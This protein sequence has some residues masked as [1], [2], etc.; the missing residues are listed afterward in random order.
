MYEKTKTG[1]EDENNK[2]KY[3][4]QFMTEDNYYV[5]INLDSL[6]NKI[7]FNAY[8][9]EIGN[10][11]YSKEYSYEELSNYRI[12]KNEKNLVKIYEL[13]SKSIY[14]Y[15][16]RTKMNDNNNLVLIINLIFDDGKSSNKQKTNFELNKIEPSKEEIINTLM[17]KVNFLICE[18]KNYLQGYKVKK[19]IDENKEEKIKS[20]INLLEKNIDLL[21]KK[22]KVYI[23]S[24]LLSCSNIINTL[25]DWKF[26]KERLK[27]ID[28]KYNSILF[29]LVYR[30][31]RDGD[32]AE[33]FHK[34]C[35]TIGP[36]I[37]MVLTKD[38]HRFGGFTKNN[39]EHLKVDIKEKQPE[40]GSGKSD[41]H[42]FCFSIDLHKIYN[43]NDL[44]NGVIFCCNK[45]GPTFCRNIF[46]INDQMLTKGGYCLK[47][48][49]SCF[50]GQEINYEISGGKKVFGIKEVEVLEIIFI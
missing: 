34:K 19:L 20:R 42:A 32:S 40:V 15:E 7:I 41:V 50:E 3:L 8:I 38:N 22:S 1:N 46:A 48:N 47:K 33:N 14:Y 27:K 24:N 31:S 18:K 13:I 5:T 36:N 44:D 6:K 45:Y 43:N 26:L 17:D 4:T 9:Q 29:K 28:P 23:D 10:L 16:V 49:F 35:D 12:L 39:W 2:E 11:F 30:A 37:T 25:E 21:E